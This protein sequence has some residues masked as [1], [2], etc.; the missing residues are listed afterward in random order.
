MAVMDPSLAGW[1]A[2]VGGIV[3]LLLLDLFVLH[4]GAH[5]VTIRNAALSTAGFIAVSVAFGVALGFLEGVHPAQ[6]FFAGYLLEWSLSLDNVF[7]WALIFGAFAV[8][9]AYQH[10]V[11]FYGIFGALVLRGAFVVAGS[12]LL[13]RL[14]WVVYVFGALLLW[15][16][17]RTLRGTD[18]EPDPENDPVLR[19]LRR[20]VATTQHIVGAHLFVRAHKTPQDN[21]P[22]RPPLL[23]RWYAT[24]MLAVLVVIETSDILFAVDSIPAIFGVT[25]EP[26]IVFAATALAL[27]GLRSMYFLLAGAR[28]RFAYLDVGL[29]VVLVFIGTKFLLTE[30]VRVSPTVS[31]GVIVLVIGTAIVA[32]M[33]RTRRARPA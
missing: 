26:F 31:L 4:R 9:A 21:R 29:A 14:E 15:S 24:P 25:R 11:L 30:V 28:D 19:L 10:R 17:V 18:R 27:V 12:E 2:L 32:S 7:V 6:E 23:R 13:R 20:R 1:L 5:E 33:L 8:P 3:A 22:D 16:G